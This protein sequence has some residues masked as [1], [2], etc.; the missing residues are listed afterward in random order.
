MLYLASAFNDKSIQK[1]CQH[2][3]CKNVNVMLWCSHGGAM[4]RCEI[5]PAQLA[6]RRR[7][8]KADHATLATFAIVT[9]LKASQVPCRMF[10]L[11]CRRRR[12]HARAFLPCSAWS[13]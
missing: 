4:A 9:H 7:L 12:S 3:V 5:G 13:R 2:I 8:R 10:S 6:H 11:P 1:A